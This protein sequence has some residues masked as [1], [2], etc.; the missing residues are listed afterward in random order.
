MEPISKEKNIM[1]KLILTACALACAVAACTDQILPPLPSSNSS[2]RIFF[3]EEGPSVTSVD[4]MRY[5]IVS[6]LPDGSG[7]HTVAH[8]DDT[9]I[10]LESTPVGNRIVY[11]GPVDSTSDGWKR[12]GI[13]CA[14][15][16]GSNARL[17]AAD[18]L[19]STVDDGNGGTV[20]MTPYWYSG[21]PYLSPAGDRIAYISSPRQDPMALYRLNI[22]G[23]D[24]TPIASVPIDHTNGYQVLFTPDGAR[25]ILHLLPL[26]RPTIESSAL[27]MIDADGGSQVTIPLATHVMHPKFS[28][29]G[30][31]MAF[32]TMATAGAPLWIINTDGSGLRDLGNRL[33]VG[34]AYPTF[35]WSPSGNELAFIDMSGSSSTTDPRARLNVIDVR[36][37]NE[38]T[39]TGDFAYGQGGVAWSP[40]GDRIAFARTLNTGESEIGVINADGTGEAG[41]V[42]RS[43]TEAGNPLWSPDGTK[44]LY[45]GPRMTYGMIDVASAQSWTL[46]G[47]LV[48]GH[49]GP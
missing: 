1:K 15:L 30:R 23:T 35:D 18:S 26:N 16:D 36:T 9:D 19:V 38:R 48:G 21:T 2:G 4:S 40:A 5:S 27:F 12:S 32:T 28:P 22:V 43:Q 17:I 8:F 41:L 29:D 47:R 42:P 14:D 46:P 44:L 11:R 6:M 45:N 49:W 24:G 37:G 20:T 34:I 10:W 39:L 25:I 33:L 31:R 13:Y 3:N 7:R